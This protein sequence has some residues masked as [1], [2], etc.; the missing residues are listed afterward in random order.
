[1]KKS[2]R[3]CVFV[4]IYSNVCV[5][6]MCSTAL[7]LCHS[8]LGSK[9]CVYFGLS[10]IFRLKKSKKLF[11]VLIVD[12]N[13][14]LFSSVDSF[15]SSLIAIPINARRFFNECMFALNIWFVIINFYIYVY[16]Y[17]NKYTERRRLCVRNFANFYENRRYA[18]VC[19]SLYI[20]WTME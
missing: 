16:I 13:K 20:V 2:A 4:L 9:N 8:S 7:W 19:V 15:F 18:W 12:R 5:L 1:M 17:M 3:V 6:A 11:F 10:D 14:L